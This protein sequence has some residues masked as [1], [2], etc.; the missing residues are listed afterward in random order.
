MVEKTFSY[1]AGTPYQLSINLDDQDFLRGD[2]YKL[3]KRNVEKY[4]INPAN[5]IFEISENISSD[6]HQRVIAIIK[7]IKEMGCLIAIDDFGVDNSNYMRILQL[8]ADYIKI[9]GH[10]IRKI[11]THEDS[12]KVAHSITQFAKNIGVAVVAEYVHSKQVQQV[13][14]ELGIEYS[15]G[16]YWHEPAMKVFS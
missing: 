3:I 10:F 12:Y 16:Y 14:E 15:Q 6:Q 2:I 9:D 5:L 8:K 11:D 1:F 4:G 13:I 7:K